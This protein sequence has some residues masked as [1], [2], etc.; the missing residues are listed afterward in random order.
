VW[1]VF[2]DSRIVVAATQRYF[3]V[4]NLS[5]GGAIR[6]FDREE[7]RLAYEDAGYFLSA[8]GGDWSTQLLGESTGVAL[9]EGRGAELSARFTAV[10]RELL[11]PAKFLVLRILNLTVFRSVRL[12]ALVRRMI[13]ARLIT[14]RERGA[15]TLRRRIDFA[16]E[17]VRLHDEIV[18]DE[19]VRVA[20]VS[21]ERSLLPMHMGSAK[22]FHA[23]E[24][25]V[26]DLPA[27]EGWTDALSAG[28][29]VR[30][31][32]AIGFGGAAVSHDHQL[33]VTRLPA[34]RPASKE[35][36]PA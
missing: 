30:L 15:W 17:R 25:E 34:P 6:I 3:A 2:D 23:N 11:T 26:I 28:S 9:S 19:A 33:D 21:L 29:P 7:G 35:R 12:G 4:G 20:F 32:Q 10:K 8:G 27:L 13:I 22:Y 16:D 5:K 24:L 31:S 36:S 18:P 1:K 14:G